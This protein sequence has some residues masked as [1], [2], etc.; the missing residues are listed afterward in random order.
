MDLLKPEMLGDVII[1]IVNILIL[2]FVTKKLLYKPVRNYL[3]ARREKELAAL[4]GAQE[5]KKEAEEAKARCD[6]LLAD[7]EKEKETLLSGAKA[8]AKAA[9]EALLADA[10]TEADEV[11]RKAGENAEAEKARVLRDA[12]REIGLTAVELAGK[13]LGREVSDEDERRLIDDFFKHLGD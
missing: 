7:A 6:A 12:D 10:R 4:T 2:F 9:A 3:A 13:I 5:A 11:L 1:N 8:E